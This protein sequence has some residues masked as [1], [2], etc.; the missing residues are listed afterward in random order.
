MECGIDLITPDAVRTSHNVE[1]V[2]FTSR[3]SRY[4]VI[5]LANQDQVPIVDSDRFIKSLVIVHTLEGKPIGRLN[6]MVIGLL[7]IGLIR[8]VLGIVFVWRDRKSTRLNSSHANISYAV[9]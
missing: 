5:A 2:K 4:D 7:K 8:R 6:V 9:F 3:C 1:I